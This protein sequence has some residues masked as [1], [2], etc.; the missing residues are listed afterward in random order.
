MFSGFSGGGNPFG[1]R[2]GFGGG[3]NGRYPFSKAGGGMGGMGGAQRQR[4]APRPPQERGQNATPWLDLTQKKQVMGDLSTSHILNLSQE[5][6]VVL[7]NRR[8][9]KSKL[10]RNQS[11]AQRSESRTKVMDTPRDKW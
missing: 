11:M 8:T 1:G 10:N 9:Q 3:W 4:S 5:P 6:T 2:G 7:R